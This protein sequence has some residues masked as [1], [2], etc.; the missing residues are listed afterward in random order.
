[1]FHVAQLNVALP[2]EPLESELLSEFV[3]ALGPVNAT[4]D[5]SPGF[6]WRLQGD[7]G[8]ATSIRVL[9]DERLIVNMSV[10]ETIEDLTA[11]VY[12]SGHVAVMRRRR[13]WFERIAFHMVLWWVP[14]G[15][16]PAVA[17]GMERLAHLRAHGPS[18]QAFTFRARFAPD[19]DVVIVDDVGCPAG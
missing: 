14:E 6:V 3:A 8:D 11:F 4:A 13:E 10:W 5:G 16:L 18:P 19:L 2:R 15:H 12:R 7:G 1:M 9:D 17:E